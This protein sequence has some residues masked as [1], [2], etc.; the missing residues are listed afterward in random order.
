MLNVLNEETDYDKLP[1]DDISIVEIISIKSNDVLGSRISILDYNNTDTIVDWLSQPKK[2]D[3]ETVLETVLETEIINDD[4]FSFLDSEPDDMDICS[5]C[6]SY[7]HYTSNKLH[8]SAVTTDSAATSDSA[9]TTTGS[10][11]IDSGID[12]HNKFPV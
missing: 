10:T 1:R 9:C 6:V 4:I 3:T 8:N 7:D 11:G 2:P 5:D 12:S